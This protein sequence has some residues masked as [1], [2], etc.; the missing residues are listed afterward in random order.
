MYDIRT[1]LKH[2]CYINVTKELDLTKKQKRKESTTKEKKNK[3]SVLFLSNCF[4]FSITNKTLS[5]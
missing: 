2:S 1:K 4:Y 3:K 5:D